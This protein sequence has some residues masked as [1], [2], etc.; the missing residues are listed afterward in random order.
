MDE[1]SG[2]SDQESEMS[3]GAK[4]WIERML[5]NFERPWMEYIHKRVKQE[6]EILDEIKRGGKNLEVRPEVCK[7][8]RMVRKVEE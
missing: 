5:A 8:Y 7:P 4:E 3:T 6:M 2:A 1:H